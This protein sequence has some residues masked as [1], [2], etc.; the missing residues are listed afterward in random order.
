MRWLHC[1]WSSAH[2]V[3]N[4]TAPSEPD[5]FG[6][7]FLRLDFI[8]KI[9]RKTEEAQ[10]ATTNQLNCPLNICHLVVVY[11]LNFISSLSSSWNRIKA[12]TS[13]RNNLPT[14]IV[15]KQKKISN[16]KV[17]ANKMMIEFIFAIFRKTLKLLVVITVGISEM[18]TQM[19]ES[20]VYETMKFCIRTTLDQKK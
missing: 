18:E 4:N 13:R 19:R 12:T 1:F 17:G 11:F 20:V 7:N 5:S 15:C 2:R 16:N 10:E 3:M 14:K 9:D 6:I 8:K